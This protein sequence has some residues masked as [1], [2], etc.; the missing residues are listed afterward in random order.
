MKKT[1]TMLIV[2]A[3][4]GL[5]SPLQAHHSFAEFNA[6]SMI[7]VEGTVTEFRLVNPPAMMSFDVTQPDGSVREW[8]VEF[9]GRLNL[10][11]AGWVPDTIKVGEKISVT[12][13]PAVSGSPYMFF[14]TAVKGDGTELIRPV[15]ANVN[16]LEE[17]RQQRRANRETGT[18]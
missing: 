1:I 7:T 18:P 11:R 6:E 15:L 13:N 17:L 2:I 4:M 16:S 10:S 12:G 14:L 5:T 9:D 8:K 3:G